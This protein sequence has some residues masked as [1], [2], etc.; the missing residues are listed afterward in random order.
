MQKKQ[1][2]LIEIKLF[3]I[4]IRIPNLLET[5]LETAEISKIM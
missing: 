4:S 3:G 5:N 2:N 1:E